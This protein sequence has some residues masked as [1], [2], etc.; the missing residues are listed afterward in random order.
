MP[1]QVPHDPHKVTNSCLVFNPHGD[2]VA[3]YDKIHLFGFEMGEERYR[4]SNTIER[5]T[6]PLAIDSPFGRIGLTVCYDVRFP[7]L[8]RALGALDLISVP[9]AFTVPTGQAHWETLLRAR[10][11]ENLAW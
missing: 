1:L 10:A 3:R 4:E 9:S 5:G 8:Y 6:A 7:E 11:I 2:V